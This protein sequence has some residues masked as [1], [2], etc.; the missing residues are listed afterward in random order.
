[1][2]RK[3]ILMAILSKAA[4]LKRSKSA[5]LKTGGYSPYIEVIFLQNLKK[6][7][8]ALFHACL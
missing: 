7:Q 8:D 5:F 4:I 1:M 6:I 2:V 3:Q